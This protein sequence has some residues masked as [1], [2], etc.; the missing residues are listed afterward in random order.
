MKLRQPGLI[1][2]CGFL[3]ACLMKGLHSTLR[4]REDH[5]PAGPHPPD[6]R[7]R[8]SLYVFWHENI[9]FASRFGQGKV[10]VLISQHADGEL[11][12][13]IC[14]H[15][16]LGAVRG[17]SRRGGRAAVRDMLRLCERTHVVVTPDGPRGPRRQVQP[18]VVFLASKTGLPIVPFGLGYEKAWRAR[19]WD[20]FAVPHP[21]SLCTFVIGAPIHVPP[22]LDGAQIREHCLRVQ[23]GLDHVTLDAQRWAAGL[24]RLPALTEE[25]RRAA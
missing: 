25:V 3:I 24:P 18:G 17:S 20:Q 5:G 8:R 23:A 15:L 7:V 12:T 22:D 19:S 11:I 1:R 2:A 13:Q 4:V 9:V 16:R 6:A 10:H 14:R 21:F